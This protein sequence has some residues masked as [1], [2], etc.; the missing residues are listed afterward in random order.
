MI[1]RNNKDQN[2]LKLTQRLNKNIQN[3]LNKV[4]S[5][6]MSNILPRQLKEREKIG[7]DRKREITT[8]STEIQR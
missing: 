6:N 2:R 4:F 5:D 3:Q 7:I 1:A 8:D